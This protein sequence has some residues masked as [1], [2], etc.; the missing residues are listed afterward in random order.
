VTAYGSGPERCKVASWRNDPPAQPVGVDQ[1]VD[2]RC[3]NAAGTGADS[4]FALS[5]IAP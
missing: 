4:S 1:I 2:V 3:F 5:Y